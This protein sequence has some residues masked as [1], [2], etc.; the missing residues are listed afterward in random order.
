MKESDLRKWHRTLGIF[1]SFFVITQAGSGL[2]ITLRN[3]SVPHSHAHG[4]AAGHLKNR[5]TKKSH[6][7]E[8]SSHQSASAHVDS[9][10]SKQLRMHKSYAHDHISRQAKSHEP[11]GSTWNKYLEEIHHGG[12]LLGMF[13][14]LLVGIGML[15]MAVSGSMVFFKI[16]A[17]AKKGG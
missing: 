6:L 11:D 8:D 10:E 5:D 17:R 13:Y 9:P 7:H 3:I 2:L 12:G 1:L 14:R 15:I 4:D 16:R